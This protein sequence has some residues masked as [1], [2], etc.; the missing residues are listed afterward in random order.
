MLTVSQAR[1]ER[2]IPLECCNRY[3][4]DRQIDRDKQTDRQ[5]DRQTD[6]QTD[7]D[8]QTETKKSV[9]KEREIDK[10]S[11]IEIICGN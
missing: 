11:E 9:T 4:T 1:Q 3:E 10:V 8:R 7:R 6:R 5:I 2:A